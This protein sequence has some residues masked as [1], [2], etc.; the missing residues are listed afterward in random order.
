MLSRSLIPSL[1]GA[2]LLVLSACDSSPAGPGGPDTGQFTVT[3]TTATPLTFSGTV[4][5]LGQASGFTAIFIG[6]DLDSG[7]TLLFEGVARPDVG[8]YTI[9]DFIATDGSAPG[10]VLVSVNAPGSGHDLTSVSGTLTIT[11]SSSSAVSGR[12]TFQGAAG[13]SG[14]TGTVEGTFTTTHMDG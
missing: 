13:T 7:L 14:T 11:S 12:F 6:E 8:T 2:G 4:S 3:V 10:Q 9:A 1:A 5:S